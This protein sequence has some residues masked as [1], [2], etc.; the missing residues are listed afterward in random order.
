MDKI[1][2][3]TLKLDIEIKLD[4]WITKMINKTKN[5]QRYN[6]EI[7]LKPLTESMF[8]MSGELARGRY[9]PKVRLDAWKNAQV[10]YYKLNSI[11]YQLKECRYINYGFYSEMEKDLSE[12]GK[13]LYSLFSEYLKR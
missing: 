3:K 9:I 10:E 4:L 6:R 7:F 11:L 12:I 8:K 2:D 5:F 1:E 13:M